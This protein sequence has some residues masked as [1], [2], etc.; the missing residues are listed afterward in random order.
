MA[1][2]YEKTPNLALNKYGDNDP[3]DL[4]DGYNNSMDIIDT[5]VHE[6]TTAIVGKANS[7]NVYTKTETDAKVNVKADSSDV[8]TKTET[9]AKVNVKA[10]SSDVYTKTEIDN[11]QKETALNIYRNGK[12]LHAVFIGDSIT[13]GY[14]A[15]DNAHRW[16]TLLSQKFGWTEH[17]YAVGGTGFINAGPNNNARYDQQCATAAADSSYDHSKVV[18]V[19]ITGGVND[20]APSDP[21]AG[22]ATAFASINALQTAYPNARIYAGIGIS[23]CMDPNKHGIG[24]TPLIVRLRYYSALEAAFGSKDV[25]LIPEMWSWI[26]YNENWQ[27][28]DTVHPNDDGYARIAELMTQVINGTYSKTKPDNR[29]AVYYDSNFGPDV[30]RKNVVINIANGVMH[31]Y[32]DLDITIPEDSSAIGTRYLSETIFNFPAWFRV[33]YPAYKLI[34]N[35]VLGNLIDAGTYQNITNGQY[36]MSKLNTVTII[37]SS[38]APFKAGD[39]ITLYLDSTYPAYGMAS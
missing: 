11:N 38:L 15:S 24:Q 27:N 23:G 8:Y 5:A 13:Q 25:V 10:D 14:Q 18:A 30:T 7:S 36:G 3:A 39:K 19:F 35:N 12:G 16:S 4:R 33:Q 17:N 6:N 20:G 21:K 28:D 29:I 31:I 37:P 9:D 2:T 1:T 26:Y 34:V 22:N 32:G